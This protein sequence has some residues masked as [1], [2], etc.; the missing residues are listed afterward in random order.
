MEDIMALLEE[1]AE[2]LG[3]T[4]AVGAGVAALLLMPVVARPA[5]RGLRSLAKG[6]IKGWLRLSSLTTTTTESMKNGARSMMAEAREEVAPVINGPE[7]G[8]ETRTTSRR[9]GGEAAHSLGQSAKA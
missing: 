9:R 1:V 5:G 2:R 8:K 4:G 6:A 3:G 7:E